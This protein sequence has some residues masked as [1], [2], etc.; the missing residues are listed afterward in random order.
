MSRGGR[1]SKLVLASATA[2]LLVACAV[3][4]ELLLVRA[5]A[6]AGSTSLRTIWSLAALLFLPA[7]LVGTAVA[8]YAR[9]RSSR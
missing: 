7:I 8:L 9:R 1:S 2:G 3:W 5:A 6:D 4:L